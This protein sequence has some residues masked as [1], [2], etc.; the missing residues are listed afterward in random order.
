MC[1]PHSHREAIDALLHRAMT[2]LP[3]DDVNDAEALIAAAVAALHEAYGDLCSEACMRERATAFV[4]RLTEARA[5]TVL[6][7]RAA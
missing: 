4:R 7:E 2:A 5:A 6:A 1:G 3:V